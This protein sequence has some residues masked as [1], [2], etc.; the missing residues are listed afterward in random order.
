MTTAISPNGWTG[1]V[2]SCACLQINFEPH[3][4]PAIRSRP[5]EVVG[6][7][8]AKVAEDLKKKAEAKFEAKLEP[9]LRLE[10]KRK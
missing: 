3:T 8:T 1:A 10:N 6:V 5:V 4:R 7:L 9:K 2:L